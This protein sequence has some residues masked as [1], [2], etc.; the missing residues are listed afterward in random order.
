M[1]RR[2]L[3]DI[4]DPR[5]E[6]AFTRSDHRDELRRC[7]RHDKD[8]DKRNR[9]HDSSRAASPSR[10]PQAQGKEPAP[11]RRK[12]ENEVPRRRWTQECDPQGEDQGCAT[13]KEKYLARAAL[14]ALR[15][16]REKESSQRQYGCARQRERKIARHAPQ[17]G[18]ER[19]RARDRVSP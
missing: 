18:E 6:Y 16:T 10:H 13:K 8:N 4:E 1:A 2:S 15:S 12:D 11:E 9:R 5:R 17:V 19:F 7:R 3:L 14:F